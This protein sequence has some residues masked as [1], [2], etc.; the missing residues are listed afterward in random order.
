MEVHGAGFVLKAPLIVIGALYVIRQ[1]GN[2]AGAASNMT[3]PGSI[4]IN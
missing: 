1:P 4:H 3:D 2:F